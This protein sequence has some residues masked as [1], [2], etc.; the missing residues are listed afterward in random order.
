MSLVARI[1]IKQ[2]KLL[3]INQLKAQPSC[4]TKIEGS[5][6]KSTKI[7]PHL[8]YPFLNRACDAII[9]HYF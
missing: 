4:A 1:M 6:K 5:N 2:K 3:S 8:N 9:L 7:P